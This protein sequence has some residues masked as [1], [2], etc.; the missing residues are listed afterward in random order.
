MSQ[1]IVNRS[2][3]KNITNI[4]KKVSAG[5]KKSTNVSRSSGVKKPVNPSRKSSTEKKRREQV[6][7]KSEKQP[8]NKKQTPTNFKKRKRQL[9]RRHVGYTINI[10]VIA[11]ILIF[12][13]VSVYS[14]AYIF[15]EKISI[16]EVVKGKSETLPGINA[17]GIVLRNEIITTTA[18]TGYINFYVRD[19]GRVAVGNNV[20]SVDEN[21]AFSQALKETALNESTLS[22]ENISQIKGDIKNFVIE[23][24]ENN[25]SGAY[26]FKYQL[27]SKLIE[28]INLNALETV[29]N[30]LEQNGGTTLQNIREQLFQKMIR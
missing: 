22:K 6:V 26:D 2:N 8:V 18:S 19:G 10:G 25:F 11:F 28:N 27:D 3:N 15:R 20:Y 17:T 4:N 24:D 5:K 13:Y 29:N 21:G 12:I 9:K 14:I 16:Y 23:F 1:K 30:T 7:K